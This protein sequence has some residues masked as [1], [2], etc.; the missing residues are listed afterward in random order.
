MTY[1]L[2]TATCAVNYWVA[3]I[4][5][6]DEATPLRIINATCLAFDV[7]QLELISTNRK[8]KL[9]RARF[10]C[11]YVM[12]KKLQLSLKKI[13]WL[14]NRDHTT[15]MWAIKK[16]DDDLSVPAYRQETNELIN[17]VIKYL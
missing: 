7:T 17:A 2:A 11:M 1:E 9:V 16:I 14:F 12:K 6:M 8:R 15:V 10:I 3:P 4:R 5:I 13:G